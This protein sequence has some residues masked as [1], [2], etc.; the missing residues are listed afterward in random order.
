MIKYYLTGLLAF[1]ITITANA[2]LSEKKEEGRSSRRQLGLKL[3]YNLSTVKTNNNNLKLSSGKGFMAAAFFAP[4]TSGLLGFR[5]E[6][7]YSRQGFQYQEGESKSEVQ[8]TY[9]LLPQLTTLNITRF[10]Q[11]QLGG[12]V[13][14]L[15]S[16]REKNETGS[17]KLE[18]ITNRIDY[19]AAG[20][21]EINPFK[22][23]LL[24]A[25]YNISLG[26]IYKS[27]SSGNIP[28][29]LPFNPADLKSKNGVLNFFIGYKF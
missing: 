4:P 25:R 10:V 2:Q 23:L 16:A 5:S 28:S 3:G 24:G 15:L 27:A 20:G 26:N 8:N 17:N 29:P 13:G 12:Q 6:V 19:G 22:G 11:L 14:F 18:D 21:I 7:V 1:L 9:L